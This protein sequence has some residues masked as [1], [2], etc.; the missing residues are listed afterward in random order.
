MPKVIVEYNTTQGS[1]TVQEAKCASLQAPPKKL[2][3]SPQ[4][5]LPILGGLENTSIFGFLIWGSE[6]KAH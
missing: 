4:G 2:T 5:H 1:T 3:Y 6:P